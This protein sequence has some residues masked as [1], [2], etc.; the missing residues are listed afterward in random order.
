MQESH[1]GTPAKVW[2][3][4][5]LTGCT[6]DEALKE[7]PAEVHVRLRLQSRRLRIFFSG[8]WCRV[9]CQNIGEL[10]SDSK[11]SSRTVIASASISRLPSPPRRW[12]GR[13]CLQ[14]QRR[15]P[16]RCYTGD[17][18]AAR[19]DVLHSGPKH[20]PVPL[21]LRVFRCLAVA[22]GIL[23]GLRASGHAGAPAES[24]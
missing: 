1:V 22:L 20:R 3:R 11:R 9:L 18:Q 10:E 7:D 24:K 8:F 19:D 23:V 6:K 5:E 21:T 12:R 13:L 17:S 15:T 4:L 16:A 14:H 2:P